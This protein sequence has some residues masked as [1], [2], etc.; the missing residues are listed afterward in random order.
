METYIGTKIIKA[1]PMD[2]C[3]FY[4]K[5]KSQPYEPNQETRE[6]YHVK[7]DNDYSS[8]SPKHVFEAAYRLVSESEKKLI[9]SE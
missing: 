5:V 3:T 2:E 9:E 7:Y 1:E 6:G 4:E 8:W